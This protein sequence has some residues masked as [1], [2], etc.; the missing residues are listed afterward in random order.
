MI[1]NE[2]NEVWDDGNED[3]FDNNDD[4]WPIRDRHNY[5]T[6]YDRDAW[7]KLI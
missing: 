1:D 7:N 4:I 3:D 5:I 2:D 6:Y